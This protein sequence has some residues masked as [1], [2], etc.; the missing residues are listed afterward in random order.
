MLFIEQ[1]VFKF[2]NYKM[3]GSSAVCI[4]LVHP[5][6]LPFLKRVFNSHAI[7]FTLCVQ[8]SGF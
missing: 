3:I 2:A 6:F 7:Q 1:F 4:K 8:F 5:L